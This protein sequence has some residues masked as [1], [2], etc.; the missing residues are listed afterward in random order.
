MLRSLELTKVTDASKFKQK[1][2]IN[3]IKIKNEIDA[4]KASRTSKCVQDNK[5]VYRI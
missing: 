1:N 4:I 3:L 2:R 5:C